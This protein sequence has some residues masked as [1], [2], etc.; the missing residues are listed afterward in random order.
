MGLFDKVFGKESGAV[1]L[2]E[3]EAFAAVAVAAIASDGNISPEEVQHTVANLSTLQL[4]RGYNIRDLGKTL[5]KVADLLRRRGPAPL[6]EAVKVTLSQEHLETAFFIAADLVLADGVV[7][8]EEKK[9]LEELQRTLQ[10]DDATAL[11]I[12]DVVII[13]NRA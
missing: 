8:A 7:E 10:I 3:P 13:K 9:F 4:F 6:I 12:V 2:N 5:D 11:K 1:K